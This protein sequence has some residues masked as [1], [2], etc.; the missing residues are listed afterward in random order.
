MHTVDLIAFAPHMYTMEGEGVG[1]KADHA[2][3]VDGG[4]IVA[5]MKKEEALRAYQAEKVLALPH[6]VLLPGL[7]DAHMHTAAHPARLGTGY[8]VLDDV[9]GTALFPA[10]DNRGL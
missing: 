1:Y 8:R 7:I 3:V 2:L 6:H 5:V 10:A 4:K 9:W